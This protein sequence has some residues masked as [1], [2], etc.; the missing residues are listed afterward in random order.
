[1]ATASYQSNNDYNLVKEIRPFDMPYNSMMQEIATKQEYWKIGAERVKSIYDQAVG[2]D[3]QFAQNKEYLKNFMSEANKNLQKINKSDLRLSDNSQQATNV[4]KPLY[5]VSNS[6][7][8]KLLADS[9]T[10]KYY[11][12]QQQLSDSYRTKDG[13]KE[14][15]QNND[16]YFRDAQRKYLEDAKAGNINSIDSHF[17]NKKGFIPY[18]D[19]KKEILD[20]QEACKGYSYDRKEV[21][22]ANDLYMEQ[23]SKSGCSPTE[24]A[25]ALQS[26]LS[27][28]AR[29]QMQI[30]GYVHFK[31]QEDELAK[32]FS[33]YMVDNKKNNIDEIK[34]RIEGIK[35]GGVS[36]KEKVRLAFYEDQLK[37]LEPEYKAAAEE[38]NTMTK[39]NTLEYI[40][41]NYDRLA[42]QVYFNDLTS[43]M[44]TAFRTDEE[45][46]LVS[47]N[48]AGML[49]LRL[50]TDR[51]NMYIQN[52]M[53]NES[54]YLNHLYRKDENQQKGEID[55]EI[56]RLKGEIVGD[57]ST[58]GIPQMT[59]PT[60]GK[61]VDIKTITET[62]FKKS[63]LEPAIAKATTT[64]EVINDLVK[65]QLKITGRGLKHGE[66]SNYIKEIEDKKNRKELLSPEA[67][68]ILQA[69]NRYKDAK[70]ELT[71]ANDQLAAADAITRTQRPELFNDVVYSDKKIIPYGVIPY[72]EYVSDGKG[73][74]IPKKPNPIS[75]KDMFYI[76]Q[77][78]TING[79]S[80]KYV[81]DPTI[82]YPYLKENKDK[83]KL[84]LYYNGVEIKGG[85]TGTMSYTIYDI[86]KSVNDKGNNNLTEIQRL[87]AD[88]FTN[89]NYINSRMTVFNKMD[90]GKA[91]YFENAYGEKI[92]QYFNASGGLNDKNGYEV[93]G[94]DKVGTGA[95]I[96]PLDE[97]GKPMKFSKKILDGL[98][99]SDVGNRVDYD[100]NTNSYYIKNIFPRYAGL[101]DDKTLDKFNNVKT[102]ITRIEESLAINPSFRNATVMDTRE[103]PFGGT[104]RYVGPV[105]GREYII[106]IYKEKGQPN[107][108]I[109]T[110]TIP[111]SGGKPEQQEQLKAESM[112]Q[113]L[114]QLR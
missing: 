69:Y 15:N 49:R 101:P 57:G 89:Q 9:Q 92:K 26:G 12:K 114:P 40:K 72:N 112:D 88:F 78:K 75:E 39:G 94:R 18:Y 5:D 16:F 21:S 111:A 54:D 2:L 44:A 35:D 109:A 25:A 85:T 36:E 41:Q 6:V 105:D 61:D 87:K 38:F 51:E 79:Y 29:Q 91:T 4:F 52:Q 108:Y 73:N 50:E 76:L 13:G 107:K 67:E 58:Q 47:T 97:D 86:A 110:W 59:D 93:V 19:F 99:R 84:V 14:W 34:A 20:L 80:A 23:T 103:L 90:F 53:D 10:N 45:K 71:F 70:D 28:R 3:P 24:L 7:N 1:M 62:D 42:G 100:K 33:T 98:S 31:G 46:N 37:T 83:K 102:H 63:T 55:A 43:K 60:T 30:D 106:S 95:Y 104:V 81:T 64:Y 77:G 74:N 96:R 48:P 22:A 56:A 66:I 113:L 68:N 32:Q 17:Q 27:D 11:Q 65:K 8:Y 82:A